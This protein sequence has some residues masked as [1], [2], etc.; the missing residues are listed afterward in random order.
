MNDRFY[1]CG[2]TASGKTAVAVALA[3]RIG[4]EVICADAFQLYRG[5]AICSAQPTA[6]ERGA[7]P[8]HLFEVL[9]LHETCDAQHYRDLALP[10]IAAVRDRGRWPI[11]VGG[12]GLYLKALTHGLAPV[13]KG[14]AATRAQL[15]ML[16]AAERVAEL[17]RLD[18]AAPGN[19]PLE[20]DRYVTRALEICLLSGR[21]QSEL[22]RE[23]AQQEPSFLGALLG[24]ERD[25]LYQRINQRVLAMV[26]QGLVAE[27]AALGELSATAA[28]A[29]GV[30]DIQRHLRGE[31]SLDEAVAAIQ[32]ASRRYAKRQVTWFKREHG[33]QTICLAP[34][35]TARMAVERILELFPCLLTP[36]PLSAPSPST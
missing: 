26:A 19:V 31:C 6:A 24:R 34:D 8:H 3:E 30:R 4:G 29:I 32:Q 2:P 9:G 28:M 36:P 13:P 18:P 25:D 16:T 22:R 21:P 27:V 7:V 35:S 33:F 14:D 1:L 10:V 11:I 23:W 15:A 5:L 20:N 17:L 12:S